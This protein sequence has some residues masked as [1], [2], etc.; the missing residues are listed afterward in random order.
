[1]KR[2]ITTNAILLLASSVLLSGC[3]GQNTEQQA[4][5]DSL[6]AK[7]ERLEAENEQLRAKANGAN[8]I[9]TI[10]NAMVSDQRNHTPRTSELYSQSA[11]TTGETQQTQTV[12]PEFTDL[13]EVAQRPM[14][15]ELSKL[16]VFD[17]MTGNFDPDKTITRGQ[18]VT[19]LYKAYNTLMPVDKQIH[20]AP[21]ASPFFKDLPPD[22]PAYKYAQALAN[23]GFSVGYEDKTFR[24]DKP[25]SREEMI[26]LKVGVDAGKS[27]EP[28]RGQM[29][30]VWKFS[31]SK[32][33]DERFTGY[34]HQDYYT[35]GP[36]GS[37][38]QRAFGKLGQFHPK[39][40]CTRAEAAGTLWQMG[41]FG[42]WG[43]T[44]ANVLK[45]GTTPS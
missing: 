20:L 41:Q 3:S 25:I 30:F 35:S 16:G 2:G 19:W 6:K 29:A 12:H 23:A 39:A 8:A 17:G 10:V 34:I 4:E 21:S 9:N 44:A 15:E 28:Y 36:Y 18:Y 40:S 13:T 38:I 5:L 42:N 7:V 24:P 26:G 43:H 11:N 32:D 22:N 14:I 1:M 45:Q 33:V 27:F 37:N 31:D